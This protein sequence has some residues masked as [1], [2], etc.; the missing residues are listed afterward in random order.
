MARPKKTVNLTVVNKAELTEVIPQLTKVILS[1]SPS[2]PGF[3][4]LTLHDKLAKDD[5]DLTP[6]EKEFLTVSIKVL[7]ILSDQLR[8]NDLSH[9]LREI[10]DKIEL[11]QAQN[12]M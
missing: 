7:I 1:I 11:A 5:W 8:L 4:A 6:Y 3:P 9:L 12:S 2:Y 10:D